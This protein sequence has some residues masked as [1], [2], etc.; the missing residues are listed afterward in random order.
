MGQESAAPCRGT[1]DLHLRHHNPRG[2]RHGPR[3][4]DGLGRRA[5]CP[6]LRTHR[7]GASTGS[8]RCPVRARARRAP[9]SS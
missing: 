2:S 3:G 9:A 5:R 6:R 7:S 4:G 8:T 1:A